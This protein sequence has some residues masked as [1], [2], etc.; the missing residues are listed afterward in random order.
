MVEK[1]RKKNGLEKNNHIYSISDFFEHVKIR[2]NLAPE[3]G[4]IWSLEKKINLNN[5]FLLNSVAI[6][7]SQNDLLFLQMILK[8]I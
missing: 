3:K 6:L 5:T 4:C 1:K 7:V 8:K 2:K